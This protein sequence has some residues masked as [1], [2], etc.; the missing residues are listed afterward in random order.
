[1]LNPQLFE[2]LNSTIT[3]DILLNLLNDPEYHLYSP[4]LKTAKTIEQINHQIGIQT[5][6]SEQL[7]EQKYKLMENFQLNNQQ[8]DYTQIYIIEQ[9]LKQHDKQFNELNKIFKI[10]Y[11]QLKKEETL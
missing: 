2:N 3:A 11:K 6:K 8:T 10:L 1:M 5:E 4:F 7:Y 9:R